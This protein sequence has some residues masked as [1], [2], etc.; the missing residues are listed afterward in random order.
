MAG[1]RATESS[2]ETVCGRQSLRR[3]ALE[4]FKLAC[5]VAMAAE[6]LHGVSYDSM[7]VQQY[8]DM[9]RISSMMKFS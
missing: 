5:V 9:V 6:T 2:N 8:L 4:W 3:A 1:N 7:A